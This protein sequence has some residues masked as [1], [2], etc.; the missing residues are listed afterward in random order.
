MEIARDLGFA[1]RSASPI[2]C[3]RSRGE[4]VELLRTP[5]PPKIAE[6]LG[7]DSVGDLASTLA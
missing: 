1:N 7:F 5:K 4:L 6:T 3:S 2:I